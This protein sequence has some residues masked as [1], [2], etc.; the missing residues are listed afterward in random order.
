MTDI[1][2][3]EAAMRNDETYKTYVANELR[4]HD[5]RLDAMAARIAL[6]ERDQTEIKTLVKDVAK[7]TGEMLEVF[8]SWRG[9]MRALEWIGRA[10]KPIVYI[11]GLIGGAVVWIKTGGVK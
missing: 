4:R 5:S 3:M 2:Q 8:E 10:A 6:I 11:V 9:A 7:N 1:E